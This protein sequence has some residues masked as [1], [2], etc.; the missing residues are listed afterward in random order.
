[1]RFSLLGEMVLEWVDGRQPW[2]GG[3][4]VR[5]A[6]GSALPLSLVQDKSGTKVCLFI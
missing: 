2:C 4:G 6:F 1:M 3:R 5:G